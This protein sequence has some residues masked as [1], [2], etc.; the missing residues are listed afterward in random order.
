MTSPNGVSVE[1]RGARGKDA[2]TERKNN[3]RFK[4][5]EHRPTPIVDREQ[6]VAK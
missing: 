5:A 1:D 2:R 6:R 4:G 3:R